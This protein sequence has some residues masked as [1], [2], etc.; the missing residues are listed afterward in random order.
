MET[1]EK[2]TSL[3][4]GEIER[5]KAAQAESVNRLNADLSKLKDVVERQNTMIY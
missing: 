2:N 3:L 4:A 5:L 1:C